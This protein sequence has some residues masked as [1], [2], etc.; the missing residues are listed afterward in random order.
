MNGASASFDG[1][2]KKAPKVNSFGCRGML[3][4]CPIPDR[5]ECPI[6]DRPECLI[7]DR[8]SWMSQKL[9][10]NRVNSASNSVTPCLGCKILLPVWVNGRKR[11]ASIPYLIHCIQDCE[12]YQALNLVRTCSTCDS[13]FLNKQSLLIHQT[14]SSNGCERMV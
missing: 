3:K 5:P 12:E 14:R 2:L 10:D 8:P 7:P 9:Y 11:K 1:E 6:P 13:K 4:E